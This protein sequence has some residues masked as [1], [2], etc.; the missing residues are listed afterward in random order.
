MQFHI[1]PLEP[2]SPTHFRT[3]GGSFDFK[4]DDR[5]KWEV[6]PTP[7]V[8]LRPGLLDALVDE[9]Q[10]VFLLGHRRTFDSLDEAIRALGA[11]ADER[12][13]WAWTDTKLGHW[14]WLP[15]RDRERAD[16]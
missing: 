12:R 10:P 14:T 6:W 1:Y 13:I 4:R 16:G 3:A 11:A 8:H 2:L 7:G 15:P 9:T 5:G